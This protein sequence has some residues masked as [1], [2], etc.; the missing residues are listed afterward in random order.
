M[1]RRQILVVLLIAL[2]IYN[3]S[4]KKQYAIVKL[5]ANMM[6]EKPAYE[7]E[8][9]S[10]ALMGDIVEVLDKKD[11]WVKIKTDEPYVGWV[12]ELGLR[13]VGEK[14]LNKYKKAKKLICIK[15]YSHI[16][17]KPS[18]KSRIIS[19]FILGNRV[20]AVSKK[21]KLVKKRGFYKIKI[22]GKKFAYVKAKDVKRYKEKKA[23]NFYS[24]LVKTAYRYMGVPYL[25]GGKS[26]KGVDC[27][28]F[29]S[30]IWY[31][32]GVKLPR[33]A[34]Q[35]AQL[36]EEVIIYN[37]EGEIFCDNLKAGDLLFFGKKGENG[38]KDKINHVAMYLK[39]SKFI[40]ASQ[41]VRINSLKKEDK[42][43]YYRKPIFAKRLN[44][45]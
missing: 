18:T 28:G 38:E 36:G 16:Y 6:R 12:N 14:E 4:A 5:S 41:L 19:D 20:W 30:N 13:Y 26:I 15:N 21:G 35:Q 42:N 33:N 27:S 43:H 7:A 10:Q 29:I 37:K 8:L 40:H 9:G 34:S 44:R 25:W 45:D 2:G 3:L 31:L 1:R 32:N 11:Y 22:G 17:S 39:N 23:K 24:N